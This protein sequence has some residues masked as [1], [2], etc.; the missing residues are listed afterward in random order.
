MA[1]VPHLSL[2][3]VVFCASDEMYFFYDMWVVVIGV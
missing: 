1:R 2:W 3:E